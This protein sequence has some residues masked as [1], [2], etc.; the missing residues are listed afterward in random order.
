MLSSPGVLNRSNISC[1]VGS[2]LYSDHKPILLELDKN[3]H[4][5]NPDR[6]RDS[7]RSM[8]Q[9]KRMDW[10]VFRDVLNI[11]NVNVQ[12]EQTAT[13]YGKMEYFKI[14]AGKEATHIR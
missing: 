11:S 4:V 1:C 6:Y 13:I 14:K 2:S 7:N 5:P 3:D 8:S 10:N 9:L 12:Q